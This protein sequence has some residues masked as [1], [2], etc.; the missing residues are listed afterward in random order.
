MP[1]EIGR[2][3]NL[4][5]TEDLFHIVQ[6]RALGYSKPW[7][8]S[9]PWDPPQ[10]RWAEKGQP[11]PGSVAVRNRNSR[12][13]ECLRRVG[14]GIESAVALDAVIEDAPARANHDVLFAGDVPR[15]AEAW[16][17]LQTLVLGEVFVHVNVLIL[18]HSNL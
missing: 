5:V 3:R 18:A 14:D 6:S 4:C 7:S 11:W 12:L 1:V 15:E 17:K 16:S 10:R 9:Y 2:K 8:V 13:R